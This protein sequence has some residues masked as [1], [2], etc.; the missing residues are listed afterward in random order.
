MASEDR[1]SSDVEAEENWSEAW[2]E[3]VPELELLSSRSFISKYK[4]DNGPDAK[5]NV[6]K[7]GHQNYTIF[8]YT[9]FNCCSTAVRFPMVCCRYRTLPLLHILILTFHYKIQNLNCQTIIQV[10]I[11]SI[12]HDTMN[13]F[14]ITSDWL[15][16]P[17][18][19]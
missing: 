15:S 4:E 14:A 1:P 5:I 12:F 16:W 19:L 6:D 9:I 11:S 17:R 8:N 10:P 18:F 7:G 3:D 13:I 2:D